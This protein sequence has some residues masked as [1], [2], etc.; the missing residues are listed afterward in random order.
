VIR[1]RLSKLA[2]AVA[3]F[4]AVAAALTASG[5][6]HA[7]DWPAKPT[8]W[9]SDYA[10]LLSES[11]RAAIDR[12]LRDYE[13]RSGNQIFV[14]TFPSLE[15]EERAD[16]T[17]RLFNAW[18]VG[19][20]EKNNGV[21]M[22]V[23]VKDRQFQIITGYG[24]E[25]ELTDA[26]SNRI[27]I[28]QIGPAF[29]A[30]KYA[31][32]I[33]AAISTIE[34]TI[35]SNALP[36]SSRKSKRPSLPSGLVILLV[37]IFLAIVSRVLQGVA[38]TPATISGRRGTRRIPWWWWMGGGGGG[39]GGGTFGGGGWGGGGGGWGGGGGGFSGGGGGSSGGGGAGG[40]W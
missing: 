7:A 9:L 18:K 32:G 16:L 4:A 10:K 12:E 22:A 34:K 29:R 37:F 14:A 36:P 3:V 24:V 17:T 28:E 11:D 2:I 6:A 35:S 40:G 8:S 31:E 39:F 21:L 38:R 5:Q 15:G 13:A 26:M 23:Y 27:R 20:K 1:I 33:S 25:P 30:G 19:S